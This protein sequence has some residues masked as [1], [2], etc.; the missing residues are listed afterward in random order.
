MEQA[1]LGK[2]NEPS[3]KSRIFVSLMLLALFFVIKN[4]GI[5]RDNVSSLFIWV[6]PYISLLLLSS[7][8]KKYKVGKIVHAIISIPAAIVLTIGPLLSAIGSIFIVYIFIFSFSAII[9]HKIPALFF[10]TK[11]S[12]ANSIYLTLTTTS[13]IVTSMSDK[14]IGFWH[15][16]QESD[17]ELRNLQTKIAL[18]I[19]NQKRAKFLTFGIYFILLILTN[20]Y[21]FNGDSLL[22]IPKADTAILQ[23]LATFLAFDRLLSNKDMLKG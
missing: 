6:F 1:N 4:T 15:R 16:L 21:S 23:S 9:F 12:F 19:L 18:S 13:I 2:G 10:N 8:F 22:G 17:I 3:S 20:F 11:V 14:L 5:G 7:I